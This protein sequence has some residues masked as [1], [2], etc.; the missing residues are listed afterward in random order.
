MLG[1]KRAFPMNLF[2]IGRIVYVVQRLLI[3]VENFF[4]GN[5][6]PFNEL[7][8]TYIAGIWLFIT[9]VVQI[10]S[11]GLLVKIIVLFN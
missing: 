9:F 6:L 2:Y 4:E 5:S 10:G 11:L 1:V 3:I 8:L 7:L